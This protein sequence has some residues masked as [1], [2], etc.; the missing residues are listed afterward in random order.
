MYYGGEFLNEA[1]VRYCTIRG[2]ELT[3]SRPYHS[4]DQAWIEQ[5]NGSVVRRLAGYDRHEGATAIEVLSRL[6]AASRLFVNFFQPSFKLREKT[7]VGA[8]VIK[9]Y[10]APETP[11]AR[12]LASSVISD[13]VK[14]KLTDIAESLDPLQ[15]LDEIRTMQSHL[16]VL[17]SGGK[18]SIAVPRKDDLTLFLSGLAVAWRDGEVRGTHRRLQRP[19]RRWRTRLDP[20]I[21]SWSTVREWLHID[22]AQN[23]KDLF[24]RLQQQYPGIYPDCQLRTLQRRLK[25]WR[26]QRAPS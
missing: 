23:G 13:Q 10:H 15:L 20:F 6:Y 12:L 19:R 8:R 4:N 25:E 24:R 22:P 17:S 16:A 11:C 3:R 7:R 18:A 26:S 1:L 2:I 5:K 9:H 21:T 14:S